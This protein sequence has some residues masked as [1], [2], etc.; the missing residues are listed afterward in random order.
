MK[1]RRY[2]SVDIDP[3]AQIDGDSLKQRALQLIG[4]ELSADRRLHDAAVA[5]VCAD[6]DG[7][8]AVALLERLRTYR[9]ILDGLKAK[10][11]AWPVM[12]ML[13]T[14]LLRRGIGK[15]DGCTL[16]AVSVRRDAVQVETDGKSTLIGS[17][18]ADI[19]TTLSLS[20]ESRET[21]R[22]LT[23]IDKL[24]GDPRREN[25]AAVSH[26]FKISL[27]ETEAITH[28]VEKLF[29]ARGNFIRHAF[30]SVLA[31][32]ARHGNNAFELL[33]CY[34]KVMQGRPNR[35][36]FL[37]ALPHL[38]SRIERP[39]SALRFLLADFCRYADRVDF[40]DRNAIMLA[41]ILLRTYN[42]ELGSDIEMTPEEV[43]NV[44]NGL[45][46]DLV[47]YAQFR[48]DSI[49]YRF[50]G[51]VRTIHDRLIALLDAPLPGNH[52]PCVRH[53]LYLEREVF[54]FLALLSGK[55]AHLILGSALKE[56][57]DPG[58]G[59][60]RHRGAENFLP[61]FL[62]H[63]KIIVRGIGRVGTPEDVDLLRQISAYGSRLAELNATSEN[64][65]S[66]LRTKQW[67]DSVIRSITA[68]DR[69]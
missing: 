63:L 41:N 45:D 37:N 14:N 24:V 15:L 17:L 39:K 35:I 6:F 12:L 33:W 56:Y 68:V 13:L 27:Q 23:V 48:I 8:G 60:Y 20:K 28:L 46:R 2:L 69:H 58:A 9:L 1:D 11:D 52:Q 26:A 31:D 10:K 30:D 29:D 42:K 5:A 67:I 66:V 65:R 55:T 36:S 50:A 25:L 57:G 44:R 7:M 49:E 64:Q 32:L 21:E 22:Q 34:L 40:S 62:Q 59:I 47:H 18:P 38:I 3:A 4:Q 51:K 54:I 19:L 53:L 16:D 61:I 43:L